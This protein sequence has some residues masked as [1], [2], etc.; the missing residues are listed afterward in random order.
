MARTRA[1]CQRQFTSRVNGAG[2]RTW[3][4]RPM[5]SVRGANRA[6]NGSWRV[7]PAVASSTR[8][9]ACTDEPF[10]M[11]RDAVG[12]GAAMR[13]ARAACA[14]CLHGARPRPSAC[15]CRG[16]A[17]RR[18]RTGSAWSRHTSGGCGRYTASRCT[19][20]PWRHATARGPRAI[21]SRPTSTMS[22]S[23]C[24]RPTACPILY[25]DATDGGGRRRACRL[26][27]YRRRRRFTH[28]GGACGE[29]REPARGPDRRHRPVR[30]TRVVRS[31]AGGR[32]RVRRRV[33]AGGCTRDVV[34]AAGGTG[35]VPPR[36]VDHHARSTRRRA[37]G[38]EPTST[39]QGCVP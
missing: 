20:R 18:S 37:P 6:G 12:A 8:D 11:V 17:G 23:P 1:F 35:Q 32:R 13:S 30:R 29:V 28:G 33:A 26:A 22:H 9:D 10:R 39:W 14:P 16:R 2:R 31:R 15:R 25:A 21:C 38:S 3:N 7:S 34:G 36:S 27:R 4:A 19:P 5:I 24:A